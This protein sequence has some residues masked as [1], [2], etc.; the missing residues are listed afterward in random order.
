M[1]GIR[2]WGSCCHWREDFIQEEWRTSRD[3]NGVKWEGKQEQIL[4]II[5]ILSYLLSLHPIISNRNGSAYSLMFQNYISWRNQKIWPLTRPLY[6]HYQPPCIMFPLLSPAAH[7]GHQSA[8]IIAVSHRQACT[9]RLWPYANRGLEN[10]ISMQLQS[11]CTCLHV[12][13]TCNNSLHGNG[14]RELF[15]S[16][17]ELGTRTHLLNTVQEKRQC[18]VK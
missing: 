18:N 15:L 4:Q 13:T 11:R 5:L 9:E 8:L 3:L 6:D 10:L 2:V 7:Q 12:C 1:I 14:I 16:Q 17:T